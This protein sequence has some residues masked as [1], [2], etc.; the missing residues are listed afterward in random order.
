MLDLVKNTGADVT[1]QKSKNCVTFPTSLSISVMETKAQ[2]TDTAAP[3]E[4]YIQRAWSVRETLDPFG[5]DHATIAAPTLR[6]H[7]KNRIIYYVALFNPPHLGHLALIDLVFL[8]TNNLLLSAASTVSM[9]FEN[10]TARRVVD[11]AQAEKS[12]M[13][14][15]STTKQ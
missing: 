14:F 4:R 15:I 11:R 1:R 2:R 13:S 6:E 7:C 3:L 10:H 5:A 12:Q 9:P 8:N